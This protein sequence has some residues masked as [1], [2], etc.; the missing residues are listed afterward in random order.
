LSQDETNKDDAGHV[1]K[2]AKVDSDQGTAKST[3]GTIPG[4]GEHLDHP[5]NW[6]TGDEP[7]TS[8]QK[9]YVAVLEKKAGVNVANKATMGKSEASEVIEELKAK[10]E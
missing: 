2:R 8:K 9:G 6:A 10:A 5:E 4:D 1:E 3:N 7:A